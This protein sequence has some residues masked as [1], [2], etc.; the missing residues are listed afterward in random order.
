MFPHLVS[1]VLVVPRAK[2]NFCDMDSV[3]GR[4]SRKQIC[5]TSRWIE[6]DL[7]EMLRRL[8]FEEDEQHKLD[9]LVFENEHDVEVICPFAL[10][11]QLSLRNMASQNGYVEVLK[12][13]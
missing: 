5:E 1:V 12:W 2:R 9:D 4:V 3:A 6:E 7:D 13:Y 11:E 10:E 8:G